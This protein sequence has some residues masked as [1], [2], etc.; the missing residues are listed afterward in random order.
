MFA[1]AAVAEWT[2]EVGAGPA[3]PTAKLDSSVY[4]ASFL[5]GRRIDLGAGFEI[6]TSIA[7]EF[8]LAAGWRLRTGVE[9]A[10]SK[11]DAGESFDPTP[12]LLS[13]FLAPNSV[14]PG[15]YYQAETL[16]GLLTAR[17]VSPTVLNAVRFYAGAGAGIGRLDYA[18]ED[19][20]VS[21]VA[22]VGSV[23]ANVADYVFLTDKFTDFAWR[24]AAGA[25][26]SIGGPF[27]IFV[28]GRFLRM[29]SGSD[30]SMDAVGITAVAIDRIAFSQKSLQ[31]GIRL[32]LN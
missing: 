21:Q 15:P 29:T 3:F 8:A 17:I 2:V 12:I 16:T 30:A 4:P 22:I 5:A 23:T 9:A 7:H 24:A 26:V 27:A 11:S 19:V 1:Q 25:E 20:A 32:N 6:S 18:F 31:A 10:F 13:P 14:V 28:E